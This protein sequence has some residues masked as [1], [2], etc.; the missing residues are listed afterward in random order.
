[1]SDRYS[2]DNYHTVTLPAYRDQ[3]H[4]RELCEKIDRLERRI[5]QLEVD[6]MIMRTV[7][8]DYGLE[9]YGEYVKRFTK[10]VVYG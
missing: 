5:A 9:T 8:I 3:E 10:E 6:N 1:M 7:L 2:V 4:E